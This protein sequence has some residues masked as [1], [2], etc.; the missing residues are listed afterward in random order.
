MYLT[1]RYTKRQTERHRK[2]LI[3]NS[4][5]SQIIGNRMQIPSRWRHNGE[6]INSERARAHQ[7]FKRESILYAVT[8][9]QKKE[10]EPD[11]MQDNS[12]TIQYRTGPV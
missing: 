10:K 9:R 2:R 3:L 7:T 1:E 8:D 6:E 5:L 12:S 4:K 11:S